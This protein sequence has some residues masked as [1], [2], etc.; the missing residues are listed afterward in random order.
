MVRRAALP[1]AITQGFSAHMRL[2]FGPALAVGTAGEQERFDVLL[3]EYVDV[4]SALAALKA[5][6]P[7]GFEP[8]HC[9]YVDLHVKGL[10]ATH[11][12]EQYLIELQPAAE[13]SGGVAS[14]ADAGGVEAAAGSGPHAACESASGEAP[15]NQRQ[16]SI[17]AALEQ[18]LQVGTLTVQRKGRQKVYDLKQAVQWAEALDDDTIMLV[19]VSGEQGSIRPELL[20]REALADRLEVAVRK[21]T[22][23]RLSD[24]PWE[25]Q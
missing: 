23:I 7:S 2:A 19:L 17:Q 13:G 21:V 14:A 1:F 10:Q 12:H 24:Q 16:A 3:R 20:L 4:D 6:A 25:P 15:G 5:N 18:L 22:R 11:I 9:E 8:Y